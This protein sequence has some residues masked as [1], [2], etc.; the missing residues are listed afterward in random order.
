MS[1]RSAS[2][3]IGLISAIAASFAIVLVPAFLIFPFRAQTQ[4]GIELTYSLRHWSP[5]ITLVLAAVVVVIVFRHWRSAHRWW[6]KALLVVAVLA[7][8]P[9]VWFARQNHFEWMFQPL[10][11]ADYAKAGE[12]TFLE[13]TDM[14]LAVNIQG[15][16]AAYP[17]RQL[18]YH[19]LVQ[20]DVGGVPLVATY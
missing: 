5:A 2:V 16:S 11:K 7:T 20:D 6:S 19:H 14:V 4:Q 18:A 3:W 10:K 15:E 1:L 12:A 13:D 8:I 9:P 17:V